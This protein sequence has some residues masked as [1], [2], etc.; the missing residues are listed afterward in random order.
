MTELLT[1]HLQEGVS[2]QGASASAE[3][4]AAPVLWSRP[5]SLCPLF[6]LCFPLP[7]GLLFS[8]SFPFPWDVPNPGVKPRSPALRADSLPAE[9][10]GKPENTGVRS[11]SL[12]HQIFPTQ[13]SNLG[14][15][16]CRWVLY[17][18]SYVRSPYYCIY[19]YFKKTEYKNYCDSRFCFG[20]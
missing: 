12:L 13:E 16:H 2:P 20:F 14:L 11:L 8:H 10:Q 1:T 5:F 18:L 19:T 17:Q 3:G 7:S 9:P 4:P 6:P 15:L